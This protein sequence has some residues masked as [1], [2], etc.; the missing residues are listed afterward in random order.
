MDAEDFKRAGQKGPWLYLSAV[1]LVSHRAVGVLL[2]Q[3]YFSV[4]GTLHCEDSQGQGSEDICMLL[5][6]PLHARVQSG[7][8]VISMSLS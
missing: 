4:N 3:N 6:F 2:Q 5:L 7:Y 1:S 8:Y